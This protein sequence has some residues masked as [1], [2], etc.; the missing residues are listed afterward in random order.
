MNTETWTGE[1]YVDDHP[2][3]PTKRADVDTF[4]PRATFVQQTSY[5]NSSDSLTDSDSDTDTLS[6][7]G[8][9][10]GSTRS[11]TS[12]SA[13][14]PPIFFGTPSKAEHER[15]AKYETHLRERRLLR[16]DSLDLARRRTIV[17]LDAGLKQ[18]RQQKEAE[19]EAGDVEKDDQERSKQAEQSVESAESGVMGQEHEA[20]TGT[21]LHPQ[22]EDE[23]QTDMALD[24]PE[25]EVKE[26][27]A[28]D[29]AGEGVGENVQEASPTEEAALA[30]AVAATQELAD[31]HDHRND[32]TTRVEVVVACTNS[33]AE[34]CS[35]TVVQLEAEQGPSVSSSVNEESLEHSL[36]SSPAEQS[37][38]GGDKAAQLED[39]VQD[40]DEAASQDDLA[41]VDALHSDTTENS[42]LPATLSPDADQSQQTEVG[43][44]M[45]E[46]EDGQEEAVYHS[47]E[48]Q[49]ESHPN[50][51]VITANGVLEEAVSEQPASAAPGSANEA[52]LVDLPTPSLEGNDASS[53]D[54]DSA[55]ASEAAEDQV[56]LEEMP[57]PSL[58]ENEASSSEADSDEESSE[59]DS[60]TDDAPGE[61]TMRVPRL[62]EVSSSSDDAEEDQE[63]GMNAE[64]YDSE[65]ESESDSEGEFD[66]SR[67]EGN[68]TVRMRPPRSSSLSAADEEDAEEGQAPN[69]DDKTVSEDVH[70]PAESVSSVE[71]GETDSPAVAVCP[72]SDEAEPE[73]ISEEPVNALLSPA[74]QHDSEL[75][76]TPSA[77]EK[78]DMSFDYDLS[79]GVALGAKDHP[80][81]SLAT[82]LRRQAIMDDIEDGAHD[83]SPLADVSNGRHVS[84]SIPSSMEKHGSGASSMGRRR[85]LRL[86]NAYEA[87]PTEIEGSP[88][89]LKS[90]RSRSRS[91][92]KSSPKKSPSKSRAREASGRDSPSVRQALNA[93]AS[94]KMTTP[95]SEKRR[96]P[97][98]YATLSPQKLFADEI[99]KGRRA[100]EDVAQPMASSSPA[101]QTTAT[102]LGAA[103]GT[104]QPSSMGPDAF[105]SSKERSSAM[106]P[107]SGATTGPS[108]A[109]TSRTFTREDPRKLLS[110]DFTQVK[111]TARPLKEA[112]G[113]HA[114]APQSSS[115]IA[116]PGASRIQMNGVKA[117]KI[118]SRTLASSLPSA[119]Q[120]PIRRG[121]ELPSLTPRPPPIRLLGAAPAPMIGDKSDSPAIGASQPRLS[122]ESSAPGPSRLPK[123]AGSTAI[124]C[125]I[126]RPTA[127]RKPSAI[128][129]PKASARP[130][131]AAA[132]VP[133]TSGING[134]LKPPAALRSRL[135]GRATESVHSTSTSTSVSDRSTTAGTNG[136]P[137]QSVMSHPSSTAA[138]RASAPVQVTSTPVSIPSLESD[139]SCSHSNSD[140]FQSYR[141]SSDRHNA[142]L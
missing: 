53:S 93:W 89:E 84:P 16:K 78:Q 116:R 117:P 83:F 21:E 57:T 10:D 102:S 43:P 123:L 98:F 62:G 107:T 2:V 134:M 34:R 103:T 75:P 139:G 11:S 29:D 74:S 30:C 28:K 113:T 42:A 73:A 130:P 80:S 18:F 96:D 124:P 94:A 135:P 45:D 132:R 136:V 128:P 40:F 12:S 46:A 58:G 127:L 69:E 47:E 7:S 64:A 17:S 70:Q 88:A 105:E 121:D 71:A 44:S 110:F 72:P 76:A 141:P 85:S 95:R 15:R 100:T 67:D 26:V 22:Q 51:D 106:K 91:P 65:G 131:A 82:V 122:A 61:V 81:P 68:R 31:L 3:T 118:A 19:A 87:K 8:L 90:R 86:S 48:A 27:S 33:D 137:A 60:E 92:H 59:M 1:V 140:I 6:D 108:P 50:D 109:T 112:S 32:T 49:D 126:A 111:P 133:A 77:S 99:E 39:S 20:R 101:K 79:P 24:G 142:N 129:A 13:G 115:Q 37:A 54:V 97:E 63:D 125:G 120:K 4:T 38:E 55:G 25:V 119:L 41:K 35:T 104:L 52:K 66:D 5:K 114:S 138:L 23:A 14:G 9:S 36:A 56:E